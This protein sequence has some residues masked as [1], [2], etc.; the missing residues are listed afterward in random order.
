MT[1]TQTYVNA[2]VA[3]DL[4]K[5]LDVECTVTMEGEEI[6]IDFGGGYVVECATLEGACEEI[7]EYAKN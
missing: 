1:T 7:R 3:R 5:S 4:A 6:V 2:G